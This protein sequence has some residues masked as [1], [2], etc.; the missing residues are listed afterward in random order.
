ML[1]EVPS[2]RRVRARE[3]G[4][5]AARAARCARIASRLT[6]RSDRWRRSSASGRV[7]DEAR[8]ETEAASGTGYTGGRRQVGRRDARTPGDDDG[9]DRPRPLTSLAEG[10][11]ASRRRVMIFGRSFGASESFTGPGTGR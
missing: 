2:P 5:G 6:S 9:W 1:W 8:P 10:R 3:A 4:R 7:A 11:L